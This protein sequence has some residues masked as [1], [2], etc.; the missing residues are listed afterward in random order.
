MAM[1]TGDWQQ[2]AQA[3]IDGNFD[4]WLDFNLTAVGTAGESGLAAF[5]PRELM[6]VTTGLTDPADFATHGVHF[7][8]E[9]E[10][11][12]PTE[13]KKFAS[14][15]DFGC[16]VG[17]LARLFK[18]F[19]GSYAGVDVDA[20]TVAWVADSLPYVSAHLNIARQ[21]LPFRDS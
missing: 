21:P 8:R 13:L 3:G 5:P 15:L 14:I 7:A 12:T 16:G 6:Y 17:R 18:G 2:V 9:L 4:D 1:K 19:A 10:Q 20:K 11:A